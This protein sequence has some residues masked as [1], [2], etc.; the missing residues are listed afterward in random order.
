MDGKV[1]EFDAVAMDRD[2]AEEISLRGLD[3]WSA[4]V[5]HGVDT[6]DDGYDGAE[7]ML[8]LTLIT[9][10]GIAQC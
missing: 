2:V 9:A 3:R 1:A 8:I 5:W 4:W 7:C 6:S 10:K